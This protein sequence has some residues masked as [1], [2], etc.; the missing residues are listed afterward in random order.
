MSNNR[1]LNSLNTMVDYFILNLLWVLVSIPLITVFPATTAMFGVIRKRQLKKDSTG[2]LIDF[3][4]MFKENFKQSFVISLLW[5]ISGAF[6]Y[7]DYL[8]INPQK[9]IVL[10]LLYVILVIGLVLFSSMSIYLFPIMVHFELRWQLVIRNS[11]F[12]SLMNP[13]LTL[14]LLI[15]VALGIVSIYMFPASVFVV[16]APIAYMVYYLCQLAFN[17]AMTN[18][19]ES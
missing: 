7:L 15:I 9:S 8:F 18:N 11:F 17:Q 6:L 12:F 3:F 14:L 4:S 16:G 13:V 5:S 2:I 10:L 1:L 19:E